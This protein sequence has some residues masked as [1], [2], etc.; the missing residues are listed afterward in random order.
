LL[1]WFSGVGKSVLIRNAGEIVEILEKSNRVLAVFQ[2]HHHR[3]NYSY[4]NG[5]HYFTLKAAVEGSIPENNSF[6][7]VEIDR[8]L[9]IHIKGFFNCEN[10]IIKHG[11]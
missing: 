5:I 10:Q 1:D 2:G 11:T 3:G 6:A 4:R 8:E 7:I 9:N